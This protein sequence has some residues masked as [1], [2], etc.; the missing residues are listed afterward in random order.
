MEVMKMADKKI[1]E[2]T[3]ETALTD[4]HLLITQDGIVDN[5]E[6]KATKLSLLKDYIG[7]LDFEGL[8][9]SF[10]AGSNIMIDYVT[11]PRNW[12]EIKLLMSSY[13]G[14]L[15]VDG[16][17]DT[18]PYSQT[19]V[20]TAYKNS[21]NPHTELLVSDDIETGIAQKKQWD[22]ITKI[23]DVKSSQDDLTTHN[24]T[25]MCYENKPTVPLS[26]TV[27]FY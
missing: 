19:V 17:S 16:W 22:Y 11:S 8:K 18:V 5:A 23:K 12:I 14:E 24:I 26:F 6:T 21:D 25:F 2:L 3:K 15:A 10:Y 9:Q 7:A 4:N 20:I 27:M 1:Q 13:S